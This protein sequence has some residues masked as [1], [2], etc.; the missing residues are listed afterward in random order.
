MNQLSRCQP[1]LGTYVEITL[2]GAL[3]DRTLT[4]TSRTGFDAI[5]R[6][7]QRMNFHDP[8]SELSRVNAQAL[9]RPVTLSAEL[10]KVLR[11][12]LQLS[13]A[14]GGLF[15][16]TRSSHPH[17]NGGWR[18]VH[19]TANNIRYSRPVTIDL[20]GIAKGHAVDHAFDQMTRRHHAGELQ[21]IVN[22]GG[23]LRMTPWQGQTVGIRHPLAPGALLALPMLEAAV[24]TSAAYY[25]PDGSTITGNALVATEPEKRSVSV[26]CA[27]CMAA[28]ALTKVIFLDPD[29][30]PL[31]AHYGAQARLLHADGGVTPCN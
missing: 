23:D 27:N 8:N 5:R 29:N 21:I 6:V 28:D 16:P 14:S 18:H 30:A 20:G 9:G 19:L 22:A 7:Q 25:G 15:D 3:D 4:E 17:R 1:L 24:A 26:F 10:E 13:E 31:L 2:R 12:A 11:F